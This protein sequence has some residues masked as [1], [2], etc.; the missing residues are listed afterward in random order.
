MY[1]KQIITGLRN[2]GG[3]HS[4]GPLFDAAADEIERLTKAILAACKS[5]ED[6]EGVSL[7]YYMA[8]N[9]YPDEV[10]TIDDVASV[11]PQQSK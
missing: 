9:N 11:L 3:E 4:P 1:Q 6:S 2:F 7:Q 8:Q 10:A 5:I